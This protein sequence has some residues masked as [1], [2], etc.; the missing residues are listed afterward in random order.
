MSDL[1]LLTSVA[2]WGAGEK[3]CYPAGRIR[4]EKAQSGTRLVSRIGKFSIRVDI[5]RVSGK[6]RLCPQ[7]QLTS[8]QKRALAALACHLINDT[9]TIS[10]VTNADH[11]L[12]AGPMV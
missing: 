1:P 10:K 11:A 7:F 2:R 5:R 8:R 9:A 3:R 12:D 4:N 6:V